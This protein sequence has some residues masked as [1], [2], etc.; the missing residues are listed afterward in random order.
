M[1]YSKEFFKIQLQF[2]RIISKKRK[3]PY[4]L[5]LFQYTCLFVRLLGYSDESRPSVDDPQ[6]KKIITNLPLQQKEQLDY[7]YQKSLDF[8]KLPKPINN[9]KRFGCFSYSYHKDVNQY[10]LH[11]GAHDPKGN[12]GKNRVQTRM[13]DWKNLFQSMF[14]EGKKNSTCKI[15]TWLLYINAFQRL[16]PPKFVSASKP[17]Y[18]NSAQNFTYWG[19]LINRFGKVK[20]DMKRILFHKL[21]TE[22]YEHIED[23]FPRRALI[24]EVKTEIFYDYYLR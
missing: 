16:L 18:S 24:S 6:W 13:N 10:E 23:Y 20:S 11:F 9:M 15:G 17:C 3:I 4:V 2:A 7:I 14:E 12:L 5:A 8:E 21:K 22:N 19:S 1:T